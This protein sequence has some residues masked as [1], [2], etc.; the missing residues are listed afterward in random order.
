MMKQRIVLTAL[1]ATAA[2][3]AGGGA[4]VDETTR[5][6]RPDRPVA[7]EDLGGVWQ[8][9]GEQDWLFVIDVTYGAAY[10][11]ADSQIEVMPLY[12]I[13]EA[14]LGDGMTHLFEAP[15]A[16]PED[17]LAIEAFWAYDDE[18]DAWYPDLEIWA[19]DELDNPAQIRFSMAGY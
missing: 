9:E 3:G 19:L 1:L 12:V 6:A 2:C 17:S 5:A 13:S 11:N 16:P 10:G 15:N 14:A 18:A 7:M 8:V 4:S